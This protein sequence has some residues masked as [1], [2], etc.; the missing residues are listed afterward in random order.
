MVTFFL[1]ATYKIHLFQKTETEDK[2]EDETAKDETEEADDE[3]DVDS[4][5]AELQVRP[6][7]KNECIVLFTKPVHIIYI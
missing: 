1:I 3:E 2:K 4:K 5:I 6:L 7:L